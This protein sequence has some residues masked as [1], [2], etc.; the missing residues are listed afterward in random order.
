MKNNKDVKKC[1]YCN[2]NFEPTP[3]DTEH[4]G[5]IAYYYCPSCGEEIVDGLEIKNNYVKYNKKEWQ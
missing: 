2:Y 3:E 1:P 5:D 4:I